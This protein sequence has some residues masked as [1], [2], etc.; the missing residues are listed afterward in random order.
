MGEKLALNLIRVGKI[1]FVNTTP[2]YFH[3]F[4]DQ[5]N[6]SVIE[7][8][9]AEINELMRQGEIDFAP[10]SSFEYALYQNDYALL[11][12][13]CVGSRDFSRS[14]LLLSRERIEGLNRQTIM[15]SKKSL[16]SVTL[17]KILLKFKYRFT[18][19]FIV[20][21][22]DPEEMLQEAKAV[23]A[24]GDEALFY[25]PQEFLYKYDL[26]ELWWNW[27][28][29]PFCF[30]VW[31]VR[32][33]FYE[34]HPKEVFDFYKRLKGNAERNLEDLETL[35]KQAL[36]LTLVNADFSKVF[37]YLF[38]LNYYLDSEMKKGLELFYSYAQRAGLSPQV[39]EIRFIE[40]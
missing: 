26:S 18:N 25:K 30:A 3:L 28:E 2:F 39:K 32:R 35:L 7:G 37:G 36:N 10:I 19:D 34:A 4:D 9:P 38:N 21:S 27:T 8:S 1:P 11:P 20:G 16:S 12:N 40:I 14:V 23:L 33:K 5:K 31:A 24:I 29:L 6:I 22:G 15:V 13:L 17:L